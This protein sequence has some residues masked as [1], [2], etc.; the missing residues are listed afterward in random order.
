MP[1]ISNRQL[2]QGLILLSGMFLFACAEPPPPYAVVHQEEEAVPEENTVVAIIPD[3]EPE[4]T[5]VYE[6]E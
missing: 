2:T 5:I 3:P 4:E 6:P 1:T